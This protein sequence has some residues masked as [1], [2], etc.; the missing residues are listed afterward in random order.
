MYKLFSSYVYVHTVYVLTPM[1]TIVCHDTP[2]V[3]DILGNVRITTFRNGLA[4]NYVGRVKNGT[5]S[6]SEN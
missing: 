4:I 6:G 3:S 1:V 5:L 2:A